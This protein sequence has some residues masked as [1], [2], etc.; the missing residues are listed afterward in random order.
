MFVIYYILLALFFIYGIIFGS[1][2]N[3][4]IYRLPNNISITKGRSYCPNCKTTLKAVDLIPL[5]SY[6]S[7]GGKCRYCNKKI[8]IR[9]PLIELLTG[10]LF[11]L[12]YIIFGLSAQTFF[13]IT[14]WSYLLIVSIID[15]DTKFILDNINIF[16]FILFFIFIILIHTEN[17]IFY[18]F[19][20]VIA[21][22]M[23]FLIY[24]ISF[25]WY[26]KEAFGLGD[27]FFISIVSFCLGSNLGMLY[28]TIFMPFI[29]ATLIILII[30]VLGKNFKLS[31]EI[32]FA[33]FIAISCFIISIFGKQIISFILIT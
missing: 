19:S 11:A 21:Y 1:F 10:L 25:K 5:F 4:V 31:D 29:V 26:G 27:V 14:F 24:K 2:Y 32:P 22:L 30:K 7:L 16:F 20:A 23:Y 18:V 33:P 13:I 17:I 9:Y 3:V 6:I 12:S 15:I 28:L 8:S